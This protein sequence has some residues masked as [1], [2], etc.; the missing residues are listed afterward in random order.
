MKMNVSK[1]LLQSIGSCPGMLVARL[2]SDAAD[3]CRVAC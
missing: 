2:S 1:R 3:L